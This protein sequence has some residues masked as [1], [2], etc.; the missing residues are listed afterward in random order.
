MFFR[1]DGDTSNTV[2]GI[3]LLV[4]LLVFVGPN[5]IPGLLSR[6]FP[7]VDE[8]VPCERLR[9]AMD[10]SRHQSLIG[11]AAVNP[12]NIRV[13]PDPLPPIGDPE[14]SWRIRIIIT[15]ETIGTVP[16]VYGPNQIIIGDAAN[17]SGVGLLM[18]DSTNQPVVFEIPGNFRENIGATT[19]PLS[20]IRLLGPR[21]RCVHTEFIPASAI[22]AALRNGAQVRAYYRIT[23]NGV[24]AQA[25]A[26]VGPQRYSEQGLDVIDPG[27]VGGVIISEPVLVPPSVSANPAP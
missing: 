15:N 21:Q 1:R 7:F 3:I 9:I 13:D 19:F 24:V 12:L 6:T 23:T 16:F 10:R 20:S 27:T 25:P 22:P 5:V 14:A 26:G 11:R 18:S 17:S 2:I 8:G 4:M